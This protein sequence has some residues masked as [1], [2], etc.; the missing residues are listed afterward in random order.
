MPTFTLAEE[1]T[2]D[3]VAEMYAEEGIPE[4]MTLLERNPLAMGL[5]E[6]QDSTQSLQLALAEAQDR[7][8]ILEKRLAYERRASR[9][10]RTILADLC[11]SL[12]SSADV[13]QALL[14][15]G[16]LDIVMSLAA[17]VRP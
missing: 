3:E 10:A 2:L 1:L 8:T 12:L 15:S 5:L 7:E 6:A 16:R 11:A 9:A 14:M 17:A 4:P 13:R